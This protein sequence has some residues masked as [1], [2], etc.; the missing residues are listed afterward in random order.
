MSCYSG[1]GG[2]AVMEGI[3]MRNGDEYSLS[4]RLPDG[5]IHTDVKEIMKRPALFRVPFLR[6]MWAFV[7]SLVLGIRTLFASSAFFEDE[8]EEG[9]EKK[10]KDLSPEEAAKREKAEMAGTFLLSIVIALAVF[11]AIPFYLSKLFSRVIESET[12]IVLIEGI[13][14]VTFL[15]AYMAAISKVEDIGRVYMYHGAEHKCINCVESGLPL[16][17]E[18]AKKS[19]RF[20]KR[21]GTSF[22]FIVVIISVIVFAFIRSDNRIVQL[23]LRIVLMPVVGGI[24]YEF[25]RLGGRSDRGIVNSLAKPGLLLQRITTREPD[26]SMLEVGI[27]SVEAVFDWRTFLENNFTGDGR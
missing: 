5:S 3:M 17:V 21:C 10:K 27:A 6:G 8:E 12:V 24:S 1:I 16:T 20:H 14:R 26:E 15:I 25:L 2:Q 23:A 7:E 19:S 11:L 4:V 18:N 9:K 22:L 13:I